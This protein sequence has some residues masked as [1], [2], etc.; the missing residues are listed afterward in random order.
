[1]SQMLA[2]PEFVEVLEETPDTST[3][4]RPN[5]LRRLGI[6]ETR[7]QRSRGREVHFP[8]VPD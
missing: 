3:R 8:G 1:M 2:R 6:H 7:Q 4:D 5:W